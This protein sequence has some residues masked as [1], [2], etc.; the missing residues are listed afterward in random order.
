MSAHDRTPPAGKGSPRCLGV[1]SGYVFK[2]IREMI[3]LT[4]AELAEQVQVDVATVQGWE[5]GRRSLTALRAGDMARLRM[6]LTRLGA[7]PS[8]FAVMAD[9][10]EADLVIAEAV[11]AGDTVIHA[12]HHP[13][14]TSVHRRDLT[15]LITWPFTGVIP[16]Q[17]ANMPLHRRARRGPVADRPV[18]G[19]GERDRY[20]AHLLTTADAHRAEKDA[21]L[22]RQAIYLLA[23][24]QRA[25]TSEWLTNEQRRSSRAIGR[26]D[27][28]P[29]WI[30]AR[31]SA[32]A[33]ARNGNRDPLRAFVS[34]GLVDERLEAV[35][36]NYWAYW[37]GELADVEADDR[38][39]VNA[40]HA[41]WD[42]ARLFE[43]LLER[44][45]PESD[46]ADLNVHTL[47]A[48]LLARPTVLNHRPRLRTQ[49]RTKI[50][51]G[52]DCPDLAPQ[53]R[54]ELASVAYA[55]RL[56]DH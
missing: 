19:A 24:D 37:V 2:M 12:E 18:L 41:R 46:H 11:D 30:A 1:V 26:T 44:L 56:A 54:R 13:L 9:A 45:H 21:L 27:H 20:F 14:A 47:W 53:A 36:L 15:N 34:T 5:S 25:G 43:H 8:V 35:N 22:R 23:F 38:F 40:D 3:S 29:T 4:Q 6:K 49:A 16:T 48:L 55:I 39:T 7:P 42:G 10:V 33:L 51:Q 17:L 50:E 52:M 28:V 32:I 31:S